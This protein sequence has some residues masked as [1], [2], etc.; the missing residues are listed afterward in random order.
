MSTHQPERA[1]FLLLDVWG[2]IQRFNKESEKRFGLSLVQWCL[3]RRLIDM[4]FASAQ[5]LAAEVG[6]HPST[7]TQTI[8][9]LEKKRFVFVG[10]DPKD[11]R[12]K[13]ISITRLG[14]ETLETASKHMR[15]GMAGWSS[16]GE[17]I[18]Q[19]GEAFQR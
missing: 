1:W 18:H 5:S 10:E 4:P 7:M 13:M 3:L 15:S 9:R 12:K 19:L 14:K 6:V 11:S 2:S 8:K 16:F 17:D